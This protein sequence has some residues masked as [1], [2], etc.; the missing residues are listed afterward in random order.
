MKFHEYFRSRRIQANLSRRRLASA[1]CVSQTTLHH[2][3]SGRSLPQIE[4]LVAL[5][6]SLGYRV[7]IVDQDRSYDLKRTTHGVTMTE[8]H[9]RAEIQSRFPDILTRLSPAQSELALKILRVISGT[10]AERMGHTER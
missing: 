5:G 3:E 10:S 4:T 2:I 1:Q 7:V 6:E 9:S 8:N